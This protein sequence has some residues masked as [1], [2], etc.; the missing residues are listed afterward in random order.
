MKVKVIGA[1]VG[2][3]KDQPYGRIYSLADIERG[4]IGVKPLIYKATVDA[5]KVVD[6]VDVDYDLQFNPYGKCVEVKKIAG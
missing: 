3:Y 6:E 4:G 1:C 5:A 2:E